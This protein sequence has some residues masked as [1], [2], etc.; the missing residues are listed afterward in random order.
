MLE[1][2]HH[3]GLDQLLE[4]DLADTACEALT[5][6]S[7]SS[8]STGAPIVA[9]RERSRFLAQLRVA[10]VEL[11]H[12][13]VRRPSGDSSTWRCADRRGR[14]SRSRAPRRTARPPHGPGPRSARN[15]SRGPIE[16]PARTDASH[17]RLALRGGRSRPTPGRVCRRKSADS[18]RPTRAVVPGAPSGVRANRS[19]RRPTRS[20]R[21]PPPS[22]RR[23]KS[24]RAAESWSSGPEQR[25][26]LV[27]RRQSLDVVA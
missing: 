19:A 16:W 9:V 1:R 7:T 12:L 18:F 8:C 21:A 27:G 14:S 4:D 17:R 23:S 25:L 13:A 5:T 11:P 6:V 10:F 15:R 24:S 20:H 3:E 2:D 22:A 26:R